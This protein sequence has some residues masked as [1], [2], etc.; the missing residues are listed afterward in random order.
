MN[1]Y[2]ISVPLALSLIV[3]SANAFSAGSTINSS[4]ISNQSSI[5]NSSN[6]SIST[7]GKAEANQGSI[8]VQG[9]R[10]NNSTIINNAS[11]QNSTNTARDAEANQ[12]VIK[13]SRSL[14]G[15]TVVNNANIKNSANVASDS[16]GV[17]AL[18]GTNESQQ[19]SII[20]K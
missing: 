19:G 11:I 4:F 1:T 10:L 15:V 8:V 2:L 5:K 16:L 14:N 12:G 20:F 13:I 18:F 17:G 6:T 3:I 7:T 9:A